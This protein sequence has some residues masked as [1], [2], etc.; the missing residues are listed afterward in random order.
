MRII[1]FYLYYIPVKKE[2]ILT[3]ATVSQWK[4][5]KSKLNTETRLEKI[6]LQG[7]FCIMLN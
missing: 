2:K 7:V 6:P 1:E 3:D 4:I 5:K